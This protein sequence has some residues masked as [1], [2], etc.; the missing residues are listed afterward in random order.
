MLH[1]VGSQSPSVYWRRRLLLFAALAVVIL[2]AVLTARTLGSGGGSRPAAAPGRSTGPSTSAVAGSPS[3]SATAATSGGS[4]AAPAT[5]TSSAG[6]SSAAPASGSQAAIPGPCTPAQLKV[7]AVVGKA[8]YAVGDQPEVILQ[9]TNV[10]PAA[11]VQDVADSQIELRVYN[12]ASRVWGSH[13]CQ[14]QPG[15]DKRTLEVGV[16]A[17]FSVIWSG[18][19]SQPS[20][21]GTRQRVG[22]GTYTLYASLAG[23]EGTVAQFSIV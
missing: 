16:P 9:V 20:C 10:G 11:C 14:V 13:D 8:S 2:L 4:S 7:Q 15:V 5:S 12:G 21:A 23:H 3:G 1:P 22:A 18:L 19:S 17:G 6:E